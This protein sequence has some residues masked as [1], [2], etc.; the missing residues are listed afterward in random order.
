MSLLT[1][2]ENTHYIRLLYLS[3]RYSLNDDLYY[4]ICRGG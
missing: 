4:V 3:S 1:S 2:S